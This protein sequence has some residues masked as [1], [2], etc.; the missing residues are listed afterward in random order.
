VNFKPSTFMYLLLIVVAHYF[1]HLF[2][3]FLT[4]LK[5]LWRLQSW[6]FWNN[7]KHQQT[8]ET[9]C[10]HKVIS[11]KCYQM[12]EDIKWPLQWWS[13]H[14]SMFFTTGFSNWNMKHVFFN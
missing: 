6:N 13:D 11:F 10:Q 14:K 7:C 4:W 2:Y 8:C 1:L 12:N 5:E 3:L 9:T